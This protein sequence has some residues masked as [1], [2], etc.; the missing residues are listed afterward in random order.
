MACFK[1]RKKVQRKFNRIVRKFNKIIEDDDIWRGRFVI[2]QIKTRPI[3]YDIYCFH[4][5]LIDKATKKS[6]N[7]L[8]TMDL[9]SP[10]ELII[11]RL[12][13]N[14]NDFVNACNKN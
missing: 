5:I 13:K 12:F 10:D 2:K 7:L 4:T 1:K 8:T 3:D 6:V 14:M 11:Y 9:Y